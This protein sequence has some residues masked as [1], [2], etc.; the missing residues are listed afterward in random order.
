MRQLLFSVTPSDAA[1]YAATIAV[2]LGTAIAA[3]LIP[4]RRALRTDPAGV[5]RAG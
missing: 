1:T 2:I 5:F 3:C 4:S